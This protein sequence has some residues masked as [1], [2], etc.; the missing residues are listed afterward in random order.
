MIGRTSGEAPDAAATGTDSGVAAP[1]IRRLGPELVNCIAAGEVIERPAAAV[2]ELV[3]NA[4]DAGA[5]QID[6]TIRDGGRSQILVRDDG[7]GMDRESLLLAVERHATS[8]LPEG[9][10][11][12][13][14]SLGFRGEALPS[15]GAVSRLRLTSRSRRAS[16]AWQL[17]VEGGRLGTIGPAALAAGTMVEI[18]DLFFAT[19]A[20]LKFLK[21]VRSEGAACR[22]M[23]ERLAMSRPDVGF[24]LQGDG[25]MAL[26]LN[27]PSGDIANARWDRLA[28]ILGRD[29]GD[30]LVPVNEE[31]DGFRLLGYAGLPTLHRV[32]THG[33][34]VFVNNRPVRDK[35]MLGAIRGAY[36]DLVPRDR[37]AVAVLFLEVPYA[38]VDVNVHPTKTEV[39]FRDAVPIRNLIVAGVRRG[40]AAAGHKTSGHLGHAAV[41]AFARSNGRAGPYSS[42][43]AWAELAEVGD[44]YQAPFGP[45]SVRTAIERGSS[46]EAPARSEEVPEHTT[47]EASRYPLGAACAQVHGT[48]IIA[49]TR[50]GVV[51]VDQH[52]AHERLVYERLKQALL[53]EEV[54][55]QRLLMPVV[56]DVFETQ[57][58]RLRQCSPHLVKLGLDVEPFGPGAVLVRAVPSLLNGAD[59]PALIRDIAEELVG[60]AG[61]EVLKG[62]LDA[63]CSTMACHGSVRAHR[64][65]SVEEMNALLRQMEATPFSGQCN[66]GRPT[67]VALK[68]S[69]IE[70]LFGR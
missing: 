26:R 61:P 41:N 40:L 11:Q 10:L 6:V 60:T 32:S 43:P 20:R 49:Q 70:R 25:R 47:S 48:Y 27:A 1:T 8:K 57:A 46:S 24:S 18:R 65:L 39:R 66:H 2:K 64:R 52:A 23:L 7:H 50:E 44:Q 63:V 21:S 15:I 12:Q 53:Q 28:A 9:D 16:N 29:T 56:I 45:P 58:D 62:R 3:E 35:L 55:S 34:Y 22:D 42:R 13:I 68:L 38:E 54:A 67:Y 4:L 33:Q 37:H 5:R 17:E 31:R 19:P 51:I 59:V 14:R 36:R 30:N 69:D